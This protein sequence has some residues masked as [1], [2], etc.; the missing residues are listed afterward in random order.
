MVFKKIILTKWHQSIRFLQFVIIHFFKDD[1]PYRASA[2]AFTSLLAIV[3]LM[4]VG[5]AIL[6]SFPVFDHFSQPVQDFIFDNFV[7]ATGKVIQNYLLQFTSQVTRLSIWGV[8]VLFITAILL[9]VTIEHSMNKIWRTTVARQGIAAFLLYWAILSLAPI[10]LGLSLAASSYVASMPFL[11]TNQTPF[12]L[13]SALPFVLS[14]AGFTFLYVVV[15]NRPVAIRHGLAG[16]LVTTIL[17]EMA[18]KG[19][20]FYLS[21]YNSYELLYGAFATVPVFFIWVYW[22]WLITLLGAEVSYALSVHHKR[23]EGSALGGFSHALLWLQQLW[24][25]QKNGQGM[26]LNELIEANN[27]PFMIDS[28][29]M[30]NQLENVHLIHRREDGCFFLTRDLSTLSLYWLSQ[31]LPYCLPSQD[32]LGDKLLLPFKWQVLFEHN[33]H[34]LK[35]SLAIYLTELFEEP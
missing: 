7:P 13:I 27:Q 6:S 5:F 18:K 10:F 32:E 21:H 25:K 24:L 20:A 11:Q 15:P 22:V 29:E 9:M 26:T 12:F 35:E 1:C 31:Q 14:L 3:P 30:I 23:R 19:F 8:A 28:D 16:G 2:L 4:T 17:F 33:N 34:V